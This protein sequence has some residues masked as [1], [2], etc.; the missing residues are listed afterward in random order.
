MRRL[1]G[2]RLLVATHNAGKAKEIASLLAPLGITITTAAELDMP[3]PVETEDN[4]HGNARIKAHAAAKAS[5]LPAL[6]DNSGLMVDGL[7]GMPGVYTADWAETPDGR[8]F[9][10]AMER[11]WR[12]LNER[13]VPEPRTAT[14]HCTLCV[15]WPD[16]EDVICDG[17]MPGH[18]VW[19][20]RGEQGHGYDPIFVPEGHEQTF[21]ELDPA[22]KDRISHRAR[23]FAALLAGP[24]AG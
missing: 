22:L 15:A 3:V 24:L 2:D 20:P 8:D 21:G 13:D 10:M 5:G 12:E 14:F 18:L 1:T 11:T 23:A 7:D 6:A 4:F 16:G 19:P 9:G 17:D